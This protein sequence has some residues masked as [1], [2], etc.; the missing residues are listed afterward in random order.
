MHQFYTTTTTE[1]AP[2]AH[3]RGGVVELG[4]S[5]PEAGRRHLDE[6]TMTADADGRTC[7]LAYDRRE[8]TLRAKDTLVRGGYRI[9]ENAIRGSTFRDGINQLDKHIF[10]DSHVPG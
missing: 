10:V 5:Q 6:L 8:H 1:V 7:R 3:V 9:L 4:S 2:N